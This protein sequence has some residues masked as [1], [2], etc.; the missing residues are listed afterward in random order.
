MIFDIFGGCTSR[1]LFNFENS[2]GRVGN[3]FARSSLVSQYSAR[4]RTLEQLNI[5]L[6]SKFQR[7]MVQGDLQKHFYNYLKNGS[8]LGDYLII[9]LLIERLPLVKFKKGLITRTSEYARIK[10][11]LGISKEVL[12][13]APEH[14]EAFRKIAPLVAADFRQYKGIILHKSFL[15][16]KYISNNGDICDFDNKGKIT[17]TNEYLTE[18]YEILASELENVT[19]I[20]VPE[21]H[22]WEGHRWGLTNYHFETEY[23]YEVNRRIQETLRTQSK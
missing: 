21:F 10:S 15:R 6:A 22:A 2:C 5:N 8:K 9:D 3:Y 18:L 19:I 23:Y 7:E 1:D 11:D 14:L 12:M 13:R 16:E 20:H 17:S 4:D